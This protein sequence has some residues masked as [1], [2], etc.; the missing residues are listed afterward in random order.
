M[1]ELVIRRLLVDL[2]TPLPRHWLGGDAFRTALFNALSM[3]FPV[4]EQ[5]FIDSVRLGLQA[6]PNPHVSVDYDVKAFIGQEATHRRLHELFNAHRAEQGL[7]NPL[8]PRAFKRL[9]R[10]DRV[11]AGAHVGLTAATEHF[12][13]IMA[14]YF[15]S[16][17]DWF[18]GTESRLITLWQWHAS[19]ELEHCG[20]AYDLYAALGGQLKWRRRFFYL[21]TVYFLVDMLRQT[22]SNLHHDGSLWRR[23]TWA[24]AWRSLFGR[25]GLVRALAGPWASYLR[26]DFH[27]HQLTSGAGPNWLVANA[28]D[29]RAVGA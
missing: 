16:R 12:T 14:E 21:T 4:G 13:A 25:D 3:S 26:A 27:P 10:L 1:T 9:K 17:P 6:L 8:A 19:E 2:Q 20:V 24:S 29:W 22:V 11:P 18:A 28:R 23:R 5:F 7:V 15:L